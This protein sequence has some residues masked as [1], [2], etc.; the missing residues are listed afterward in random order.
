VIRPS[1]ID[2]LKTAKRGH[3]LPVVKDISADRLT[4]IDAFYVL[5]ASYLLESAGGGAFGRYSFLGF[6]RVAGLKIEGEEVEWSDEEGSR[7]FRARDPMRAMGDLMRSRPWDGEGDL[8]PFPGGAVGYLGYDA[9]RLWEKLPDISDKSGLDLPDGLFMITRYTLVFDNLMHSLRIVCNQRIGADPE[10]DYVEAIRGIERIE[11][12]LARADADRDAR[13]RPPLVGALSTSMQVE[14]YSEGVRKAKALIEE[15]EAIQVVLSRSFEASFE[16]SPFDLYRALRQVNPSPYMFYLDFGS[17]VLLGASPEVMVR[18]EGGKATMRPIAGTRP[19]GA[20][21]AEDAALRVELLAD[22]KER[23]EHTMLIDLARNDLGRVATPGSVSVDR[24]MEVESYSHVMHIVSE[25]SCS[26]AQ[27]VDVYDVIRATFPA[28]TVSGAPKIRAME[29]IDALEPE[30]RGPYA[31]LVGYFS[32]RGGFDS[33]IAI[34][35]AIV[36]DGK[37]RVQA[38]AGIVYDSVPEREFEE[39]QA[40]AQA[41][42]TAAGKA[43]G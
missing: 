12:E 31:G 29:I 18:V 28:G 43:R 23:A 7:S 39:T 27:G 9:A 14:E 19:R 25:V 32:Y 30:R 15:G 13:R 17:F 33:C 20:S 42:L 37:I 2:F 5:G 1:R 40:K 35:S 36:K 21:E 10:V 41:M 3:V 34:R 38:G 22:E 4:P 6:E 8:S 11:A 24:M 16:G 26:L